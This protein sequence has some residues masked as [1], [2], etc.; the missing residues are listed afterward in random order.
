MMEMK[1]KI[2]IGLTAV[3]ALAVLTGSV[4]VYSTFR[5]VGKVQY[6]ILGTP[7][8]AFLNPDTELTCFMVYWDDMVTHYDNVTNTYDAPVRI[9]I[10]VEKANSPDAA[11]RIWG[12]NVS[13]LKAMYQ[14]AS[15]D[16]MLSH[17]IYGNFLWSSQPKYMDIAYRTTGDRYHR[18]GWYIF[19]SS[20]SFP[21][22]RQGSDY[23]E[24][25]LSDDGLLMPVER[26]CE[27]FNCCP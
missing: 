20:P 8:P 4:V 2:G 22:P 15:K 10:Q 3:I 6:T 13:K 17:E 25:F 19:T 11:V 5:Q 16:H 27:A 21:F 24:F 23:G 1:K 9:A 18:N 12:G 7:D 26:Q 14:E